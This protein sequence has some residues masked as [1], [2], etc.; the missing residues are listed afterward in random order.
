MAKT[1]T[2][3][4]ETDIEKKGRKKKA[5]DKEVKDEKPKRTIVRVKSKHDWGALILKARDNHWRRLQVTVQIDEWLMAGK[6]ANLDAAKAMLKARGLED[7][8][9]AIAEIEDPELK[10]QAIERVKT[11]EG[12]CE[13]SRRPGKPG[14]WIP[15]NNIKAGFKENWSVLGLM[16][17]V[18][19]SRKAIAEGVFIFCANSWSMPREERDWIFVGDEPAIHPD[20]R[21]PYHTAVSHSQGPKGPVSSIKRHEFVVRPHIAFDMYVAQYAS[22]E[23]KLSDD[24]IA[25]ALVHFQE[26]G[27]G[28]CRS[29]GFGKF[30]LVS[31][32]ELE[33]TEATPASETVPAAPAAA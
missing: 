12:L 27:L 5:A 20:T 18:R 24:D 21:L 32:E 2:E 23:D 15:A 13:F 10:A 22:V 6:P 33:K 9:E 31:V 3:T 4:N 30:T 1:E 28:A 25:K 19:G 7:H 8:V 17:E 29:Q 16:N 11:D 26:H 14:L